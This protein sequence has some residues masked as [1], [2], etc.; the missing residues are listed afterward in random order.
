MTTATP[1]LRNK[2]EVKCELHKHT[3]FHP[4]VDIL[5][6]NDCV[7]LVAELPGSGE[8]DTDITLERNVLK[9]RATKG[10]PE[11][12]SSE[13][14]YTESSC[15]VYE[16]IF[17]ISDAIDRDGIEATVK[18]G[19]LRLVLPKAKQAISRTVTVKAG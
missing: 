7:T 4:R 15:G 19:L 18:D 14:I 16:R 3:L 6:T 13:P 17:I 12:T 10:L 5:E 1:A 8:D 11:P 9:I 2:E